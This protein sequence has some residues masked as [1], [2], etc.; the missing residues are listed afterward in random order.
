MIYI[1]R[2][3]TIR[4][5][6]ASI[7]EQIILYKGD[8]NVEV[9]FILK[10]NPFKNK[11]GLNITHGQLIINRENASSIFSS[12][13]ETVNGKVLFIIT[14]D[15]IDEL[16]E[17]G[18]YDFQI[19]LFN[20][21]KSSRVTL[22][23]IMDGISIRKPLCEEGEGDGVNSGAVNYSKTVAG[24]VLEVFDEDGNYNKTNW[25]SGDIITDTRLNKVEEAL[26]QINDNIPTDY[27]TEEYVNNAI[28]NIDI[29]EVDFTGYATESY[30]NDAIGNINAI[31]DAING[32][33]V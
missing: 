17:C 14:G 20:E 29:P 16:N 1:E 33:E 12:V 22:T 30:V 19:R 28:A 8:R 10:N 9:Q 11:N 15:M 7:D 32:E 5:N 6:E 2:T 21:D 31:L 3:I 24:E 23:P 25:V 18:D 27:V 26:Y 13:S 4:N